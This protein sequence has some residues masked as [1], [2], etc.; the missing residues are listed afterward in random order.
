MG[1]SLPRFS[2]RRRIPRQAVTLKKYRG[3]TS[4]VSKMS[5]NEDATAPLGYSE[6][7]SVKNSV[8]EPIPEFPQHPEKGSKCSSFVN[9]QDA[10]DVLPYQ[11]SGPQSASKVSVLNR[12]L[13]TLS[14]HSCSETGDAEILARCSSDQKVDCSILISSDRSEIANVRNFGIVVR[15][16]RRRK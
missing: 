13:A 15:Q 16:N 2:A 6:V 3:G 5:D 7:L 9:R 8:G 14:I 4:P 1:K 11:P 12:E 10:G